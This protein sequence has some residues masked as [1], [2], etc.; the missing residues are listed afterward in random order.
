GFRYAQIE[1]FATKPDTSAATAVFL[2]TAVKEIGQFSCSDEIINQIQKNTRMATYS[3]MYGLLTDSPHREKNAWTGDTNVSTEQMLFN[4]MSGPIWIKWLNDIKDSMKAKGN[5]PCMVPTAGWGYNWGNG[6]DYSSVL[7]W[8]PDHM[9]TY[10]SDKVMICKY[11]EYMKRNMFYMLS[12][13]QDDV[14]VNDYG[15]GDWCAPFEG[16]AISVN[17]S[18]FKAPIDL[19]D[20]ACMYTMA[21]VLEKFAKMVGIR[22][23]AKEFSKIAK[24]IKA[25]FRRAFFDVLTGRLKG[26]GQTC[27]AAML[28]HN[29]YENE[30]EYDLI[31]SHLIR[32]INEAD[33]HLDYGILGN[34]YVN[35]ILG[36]KGRADVIYSMITQDTFP[37]FANC[38]KEL[39]ATTL[40]ECW[41]GEGSRNHHMFGDIS[42]TFF[43]YFAGIQ[44][45][46]EYPGFKRFTLAPGFNTPL[47]KVDAVYE[48]ML[49]TIRCSYVKTE[50]S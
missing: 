14:C 43:K 19:T 31:Y 47:E 50:K 30:K 22:E 32:T 4:Y 8:L 11:Y 16:P 21:N 24:R 9:N 46:T 48:S 13:M 5:I 34:K 39:G 38:I 18:S 25:G 3:N 6:P 49:G 26:D 45:D 12:M 15:V 41:N 36:K 37:S 33:G 2:H 17:M 10:Y 27:Y 7:T 29:L 44:P 1:G 28:Y 20:T 23:D 35:N 42:A 40:Y